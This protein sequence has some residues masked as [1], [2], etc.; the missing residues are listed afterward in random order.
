MSKYRKI[1]IRQGG[2]AT[3][4]ECF[5]II[6]DVE[7]DGVHFYEEVQTKERAE[8]IVQ[9]Y[10]AFPDLLTACESVINARDRAEPYGGMIFQQAL[11]NI[12]NAYTAAK[13]TDKKPEKGGA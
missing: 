10:N 11:D 12:E 5:I 6:T 4:G 13:P 9:A 1:Q 7:T 3:F 8:C 2:K